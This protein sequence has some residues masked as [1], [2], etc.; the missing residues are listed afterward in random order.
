MAEALE[1]IFSSFWTWLGTLILLAVPFSIIGDI[2]KDALKR[3]K[4]KP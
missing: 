2:V 1:I 4:D 3:K